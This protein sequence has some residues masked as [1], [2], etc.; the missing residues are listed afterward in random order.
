MKN[1]SWL[2][3]WMIIIVFSLVVGSSLPA[4]AASA[5]SQTITVKMDFKNEFK[6]DLV[7]IKLAVSG[8]EKW[9]KELLTKPLKPGET[10]N[11]PI[12]METGKTKFDI[13]L[14]SNDANQK[15]SSRSHHFE[16][17]DLNEIKAD[18]GGRILFRYQTMN[19]GLYTVVYSYA[20]YLQINQIDGKTASTI[21]FN[22][23]NETKNEIETLKL[24]PSGKDKWGE[25]LLKEPLKAGESAIIP[26]AVTADLTKWD[27]YGTG[28]TLPFG[29]KCKEIDFS[30]LTPNTGGNLAIRFST[31][32]YSI[33]TVVSNNL[34]KTPYPKQS[35]NNIELFDTDSDGVLSADEVIEQVKA[36][37]P[38]YKIGFEVRLSEKIHTI[39]K[40]AF[41]RHQ[42]SKITI[43]ATVTTIESDAFVN[44][45]KLK[46]VIFKEGLITI[47]PRAFLKTGLT[48]VTLPNSLKTISDQVFNGCDQLSNVTLGEGVTSIG[49]GAFGRTIITDLK[50][51]ESLTTIGYGAFSNCT[52]LK[53]IN[54]ANGVKRIEKQAFTTCTALK[55]INLGQITYLGDSAFLQC[56]SLEKIQLPETLESIGYN[57]FEFCEKLVEINT[58]PNNKFFASVDGVLYGKDLSAVYA[59]PNARADKTLVLPSKVTT[60]KAGAFSNTHIKS[61]TLPI[62]LKSIEN[63]S[64]GTCESLQGI[65]LPAGLENIGSSAFDNCKV[66]RGEIVIPESLKSVG[67]NAFRRTAISKVTIN[68][69]IA[70]SPA[71]FIEC[72]YLES[73]SINGKVSKIGR[74]AFRNCSKLS[75]ISLPK[76]LKVIESASFSG[77]SSLT[78]INL[79]EGL[80]AIGEIDKGLDEIDMES[81]GGVFGGCTRLKSIVM[82]NSVVFLE[83]EAFDGCKSLKSVTLSRNPKFTTLMTRTFQNNTS[84]VEIIIPKNIIQMEELVFVN[85]GLKKVTIEPNSL[86]KATKNVFMGTT[87]GGKEFK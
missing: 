26:I 53:T 34:P 15:F 19:G 67:G 82:P 30:R 54:L 59:Y 12:T 46:T 60:I 51:P 45:E 21:M 20:D 56:T 17:M 49:M 83:R 74:G 1:N 23:K 70:L 3:T 72:K 42:L 57:P 39:G 16:G 44:A 37:K 80:T 58:D 8:T 87:L 76:T 32:S 25:N 27:I 68:S 31:I 50:L 6:D 38:N 40:N 13:R 2:M 28:L 22:V 77:C 24:S 10:I 7:S 41:E 52:K 48:S 64:F 65:Q 78:S 84:L 9:G 81:R 66:L 62:G 47:E 36:A 4:M 11:I 33:E 69:N 43:P 61:V 5:S 71:M 18:S 85:S 63:N 55:E 35:G 86:R 73:V 75:N 29:F 79:P 14:T